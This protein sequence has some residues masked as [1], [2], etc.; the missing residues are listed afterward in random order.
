[1]LEEIRFCNHFFHFALLMSFQII[2][3][4]I[5]GYTNKQFTKLPFV[6]RVLQ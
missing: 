1:M 3:L 6:L 4:R 2:M 5:I